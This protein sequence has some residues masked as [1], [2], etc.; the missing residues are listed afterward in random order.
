MRIAEEAQ[1]IKA[2]QYGSRKRHKAICALLNKVILNNIFRQLRTAG[3]LAINDAKG[4]YD[5]INHTFAILVLLS[6]GLCLLHAQ[7]VSKALQL[8]KHRIKT[9]FGVSEPA[10]G[11]QDDEPLMGVGQGNA[12][13][14][15]VWTLISS[16]LIEVTKKT[17]SWRQF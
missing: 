14:P 10:Y 3:A 1:L 17:R 11:I 15:C 7:I 16:K 6:F 9:G 4:C 13:G 8:A 2:D 12:Q 5:R